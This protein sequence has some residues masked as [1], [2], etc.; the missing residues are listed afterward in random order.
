MNKNILYLFVAA[1][2]VGF[3]SCE[4]NEPV[5]VS[6]ITNV[7]MEL[8]S[9]TEQSNVFE[10]SG[11]HTINFEFNEGQI[12]GTTV[13]VSVDPSSTA[14]EGEDF[15]LIDHR[16]SVDP[17]LRTGSFTYEILEDTDPAEGTENIVFKLQRDED[18]AFGIGT[19]RLAT[20][21]IADSVNT[22]L[23]MT[24]D[25]EG[26]FEYAGDI[27]AI[28]PF[29]DMDV[30]VLDADGNDLGIYGAATGACPEFLVF[31]GMPDGD[32]YLGSNMWDT[33]LAG[34]DIDSPITATFFKWGAFESSTV[35]LE[36]W[37]SEEVT[38]AD[39]SG[40]VKVFAKV[41]VAGDTYTVSDYNDVVIASGFA[42]HKLSSK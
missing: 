37:N 31:S 11:V 3:T 42:A 18:S 40:V 19:P 36:G 26:E 25:W 23:F 8:A 4:D 33:G 41:T 35:E 27:Y 10:R 15:N 14:V 21:A 6:S 29:V 12:V 9:L 17:Y 7:P 30:L 28:C 38:G 32:Y 39:G 20:V 24:F 13:A 5:D 34:L 16:V 22:D 1:L 2:L